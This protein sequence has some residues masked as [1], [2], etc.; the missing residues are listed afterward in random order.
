[1]YNLIQR[2]DKLDKIIINVQQYKEKW[3]D[4][5]WHKTKRSETR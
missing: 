4:N 5:V 2:K 3:I 1:M